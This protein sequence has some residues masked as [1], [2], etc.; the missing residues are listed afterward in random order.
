MKLKFL[1]LTFFLSSCNNRE[2]LLS[3]FNDMAL[4][5]QQ[6]ILY[7]DNTFYIEMGAGGTDG[8]YQICHDT[9]KLKYFEKP[10]QNWPNEMLIR[11]NCFITIDVSNKEKY[12]KINRN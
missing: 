6:F 7:D 8:T 1:V 4:G 5:S 10:S 3:G 9:V 11:K 2:I 12:L